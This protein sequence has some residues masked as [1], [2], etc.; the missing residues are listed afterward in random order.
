MIHVLTH[1]GDFAVRG[2]Q[3]ADAKHGAQQRFLGAPFTWATSLVALG[4]ASD[5]D[6][7]IA[8][9]IRAKTLAQLSASKERCQ[10][11]H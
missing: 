6:E 2:A 8:G 4:G 5:V 11:R 10:A 1:L 9:L 3:R 7:V